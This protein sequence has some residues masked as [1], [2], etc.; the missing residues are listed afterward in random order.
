MEVVMSSQ[1]T[2]DN[3]WQ[4]W[5]SFVWPDPVASS[6]RC[7]YSDN[8]EVDFYTMEH[9]PGNYI[10]VTQQQYVLA[11]KPARV[12]DGKLVVTVAKSTVQKLVPVQQHGT[13][14]HVNNVCVVVDTE[15]N[16]TKWAIKQDEIN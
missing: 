4:V 7:Y 11:K 9:L 14:C 15:I 5:N 12:V 1:E 3:F 6:Y 16:H 13:S 8:G 10:E 2:T